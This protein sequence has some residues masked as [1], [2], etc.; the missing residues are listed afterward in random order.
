MT[1]AGVQEDLADSCRIGVLG[2]GGQLGRCL[3]RGI[4]AARDLE[5]CF[6]ATR[7]DIDLTDAD[8][9]GPWL[10]AL[11]RGLPEAV[12]N[13][14]AYT[15]VDSCESQV[16]LAYSTNALAPAAWACALAERGIRFL[17][18]STD[19]VFPGDGVRPYR[20]EDQSDPRTVYGAS[21]R[22]G[23][24]AVLGSDP[25]ALVVRTSWVF[26]PGRNFVVAILDQA[27]RRRSGNERGP[28]RV[29]DDQLGSPTHA[30]DLAQALLEI[31]RRGDR[32]QVGD[33]G[34]LHLCNAG[35]TTWFGFA[36]EI[37]DQAGYGDVEI[38]PVATS[39]FE[40]AAARPAYSVL[41]C[42]RAAAAGIALRHW[43]EALAGYLAGPDRPSLRLEADVASAASASAREGTVAGTRA[44]QGQEESG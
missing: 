29:V 33:R 5:L 14:A 1:D 9:I 23:E 37:L 17:H 22:A 41:D 10:D 12:V 24:V 36:R 8:A 32:G 18:L 38:D 28:L 43:K 4:E 13:A 2:A 20:E 35:E 40:T 15:K 3:V 6:A 16:E 34:L 11:P 30:A 25:A 31:C 39:A 44:Q 26:G 42:G 27:A 21:K 7:D 19:Y